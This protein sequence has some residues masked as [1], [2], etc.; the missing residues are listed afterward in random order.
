VLES[1]INLAIF[2]FDGTLSSGH[3]WVGISKHH[4]QN[5]VK[6][7]TLYFYLLSHLPFWLA[8]KVKLYSD[9][10]NRARWG[11]DIPVLL[12]GFTQE[13]V[14]KI[15]EWV[16]DHYFISLLRKDVVKILEEHKN[17]GDKVIILSGMVT[18]FLE[19]IG[20]RIGVDYI[21][22][23]RP[24]LVNNI[25]TGRIIQPLCFGKNKAKYL[26]SFIKEKQLE[27][28]LEHSS[29]FADSIYD[30][31]VLQLVGNPVATYPDKELY[32][33]AARHKWQI[34]GGITSRD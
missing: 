33:L 26:S 20:S 24:E 22:G 9:E 14:R 7:R 27:V 10:K 3:L 23:T 12:K 28:D 5:K 13:E 34:I 25:Y 19:V 11:E 32:Q 6:R 30:I 4:R 15:F 31:S 2:D 18:D 16:V 17:K 29:A 21:V 1:K 8:A